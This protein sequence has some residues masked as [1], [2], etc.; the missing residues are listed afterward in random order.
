MKRPPCCNKSNVKRG[1]W[2]AEEDAKILAYASARGTGLDRCRKCCRL[3]WTNNLLPELKHDVFSAEEEQLII[4][5]HKATGSR[6][7]LIAK[8]GIS[9]KCRL[10]PK[11]GLIPKLPSS[12]PSKISCISKI[13]VSQW[14]TRIF[15]SQFGSSSPRQ[16]LSDGTFPN[17]NGSFPRIPSSTSDLPNSPLDRILCHRTEAHSAFNN[18]SEAVS[19]SSEPSFVKTILESD[20]K[21][22]PRFPQLLDDFLDY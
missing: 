10:P 22:R 9:P 5:L 1:L 3:R 7:S 20:S 6:W 8:I 11:L 17:D 14:D 15:W 13:Q 12:I 18:H 4:S 19:P 2:T 21:M 16:A